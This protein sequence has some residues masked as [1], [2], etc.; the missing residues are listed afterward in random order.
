MKEDQQQAWEAEAKRRY[1]LSNEFGS[2]T[3]DYKTFNDLQK[4]QRKAFLEGVDYR[5]ALQSRSVPETWPYTCPNCNERI[6]EYEVKHGHTCTPQTSV[7]S[8]TEGEKKMRNVLEGLQQR[9]N[10]NRYGVAIGE[11]DWYKINDAL[12]TPSTGQ[13]TEDYRG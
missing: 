5:A 6:S 12:S 4:D 1:P 13:P 9:L 8:Q 2:D 11:T 3:L 10:E 7:P